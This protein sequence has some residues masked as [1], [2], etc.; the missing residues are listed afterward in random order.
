MEHFKKIDVQTGGKAS[1]FAI[2]SSDA[3][4]AADLAKR[5]G[6]KVVGLHAHLGSGILNSESWRETALFLSSLLQY[7][8]DVQFI[9][10]GG[11]LGVVEREGQH[12]LVHS[13]ILLVSE[14][15]IWSAI[16][17]IWKK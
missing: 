16:F 4:L 6:A 2:S 17:R 13:T 5:A 14:C 15:V 12:S 8:P 9:D 3:G 7:F 11:G 10:A 1:K